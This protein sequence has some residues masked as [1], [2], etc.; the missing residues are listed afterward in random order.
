MDALPSFRKPPVVETVLAVQ[1]DPIDG[2]SNAHLGAFWKSLGEPWGNPVD[3][4]PLGRAAEYF[5]DDAWVPI[6]L[7]LRFGENAEARLRIVRADNDHMIQLQNGWFIYNWR[8]TD[9]ETEYPRYSNVRKAFDT[10]LTKFRNYLESANLGDIRPNMWE[11]TYVNHIEQGPLWKTARDWSE[12]F[13]RLFGS[14][15]TRSGVEFEGARGEWRYI[16]G[17]RQGRLRVFLDHARRDDKREFLILRLT[18]RGQ[19][20]S[21]DGV[22]RDM[23]VGLGLGH[24][25]IVNTFTDITST[26]AHEL[27][28]KRK[29]S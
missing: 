11:V 18:A 8:R 26:R 25:A 10:H 23:D 20:E 15:P 1:F 27:W 13:P 4:P 6:G 3:V 22:W 2:L 16:L 12:L 9:K 17:A 29:E 28:E 5:D 14:S 19:L 21:S 24:A 7:N